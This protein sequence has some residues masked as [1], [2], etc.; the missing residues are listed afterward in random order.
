MEN[1]FEDVSIF[2]G[3]RQ[4][5]TPSGVMQFKLQGRGNVV[6]AYLLDGK[7]FIHKATFKLSRGKPTN[8]KLYAEFLS[9]DE[10]NGTSEATV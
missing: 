4:F 10:L 5:N 8:K 2:Q 1:M 7:S 3:V 6:H 9:A